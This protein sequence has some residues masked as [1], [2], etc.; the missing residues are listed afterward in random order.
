MINNM[1]SNEH[2]KY[3]KIMVSVLAFIL[4][5]AS[6]VG[7]FV[8]QR[9]NL[10]QNGA[11]SIKI[12][13]P[14]PRPT[15]SLIP[16]PVKGSLT[17]NEKTGKKVFPVGAPFTLELVASSNKESVAGYD[18]V[19]SYDKTALTRQSVEN[20]F[21]SFRIFTTDRGAHLAVSA[22]KN[23]SVSAP[24]QFA[25]TPLLSFTFQAK[26][27]GTYLFSLKPVGNESSKLVNEA[28]AVTYPQTIDISIEIN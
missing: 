7:Y 8:S 12:T 22:T 15:P 6:I 24:I 3:S 9:M 26:K 14:P 4:L 25:Y 19:L 5:A 11:T 13:S 18:V 17:L 2:A 23:L 27:K 21:D 10:T 16:Y 28:A 1:D 20:K